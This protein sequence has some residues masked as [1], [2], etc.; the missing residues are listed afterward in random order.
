MNT[1][2]LRSVFEVQRQQV[3]ASMKTHMGGQ[4]ICQLHKDGHV[5]G[6]MKY[7]EGR[8]VVLGAILRRLKQSDDSGTDLLGGLHDFVQAEQQRW[9]SQ[10]QQH[11]NTEQPSMSWIAYSQGGVDA[12]TQALAIIATLKNEAQSAD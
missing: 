6:G 11:Q 7:D 3:E 5:T 9:Q 12:C 8:L 2:T 1:N 10:L 4:T